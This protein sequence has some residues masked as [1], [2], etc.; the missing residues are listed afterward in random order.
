MLLKYANGLDDSP[1]LAPAQQP[2]AKS[3][4]AHMTLSNDITT[5]EEAK[6][7]FYALSDR[8]TR[9]LRGNKLVAHT[10]QITVKTSNFKVYDRQAPLNPPSHLSSEFVQIA[11][12]LLNQKMLLARPIRL[13]GIGATGLQ[14]ENQPE[15]LDLFGSTRERDRKKA[16]TQTLD[17]INERYGQ[18]SIKRGIFLPPTE[19]LDKK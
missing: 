11:L 14:P 13:L 15:Q 19:E 18:G 8:V 9:E 5:L 1:V 2:D 10:V 3:I 17:Q 4:G 12:Q 16:L 7:I 6:P